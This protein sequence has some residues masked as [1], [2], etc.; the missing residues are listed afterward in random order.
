[1]SRF[2]TNFYQT[3][4][5]I[6]VRGYDKGIRTKEVVNYKPYIFLPKKEGRYKTLDGKSVD[7]IEFDSI[8]EARDFIKQYS[9]V[10]N[11]EM[12]GLTLFSY[13]YIYDNYKGE[14][15]FDPTLVNVVTIDIEVGGD[16]VIGFPNIDMADQP[17]SEEH[18]S[19]LQSH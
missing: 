7:K 6:F 9:D 5:K 3:G 2:Y 17:R 1:M 10:S 19:E 12:Y 14:I 4:N 13:L 11:F 15:R 18:T 16:D 8:S